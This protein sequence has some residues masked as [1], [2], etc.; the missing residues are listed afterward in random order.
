M[1]VKELMVQRVATVGPQDGLDRAAR[2]MHERDCGSLPVVDAEGRPLAMVTDRD[3]C[4]A[5]WKRDA[6]LSRLR[7][8]EAMSRTI[9]TCRPEDT[10]EE[11]ERLM[12]LHQVRRLPVVDPQGRLV[13]LLALDDIAREARREAGLIAPAVESASV[14]RTVGEIA[15]PHIVES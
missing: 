15:R 6:P 7:V 11:A 3:I 1:K 9:H 14:G 10:L 12:G 2:L 5:A 4:L 13:G 8:R